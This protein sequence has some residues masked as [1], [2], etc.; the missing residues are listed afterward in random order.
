MKNWERKNLSMLIES[1]LCKCNLDAII[2]CEKNRQRKKKTKQRIRGLIQKYNLKYYCTITIDPKIKNAELTGKTKITQQLR[3]M[4]ER[5]GIRYCFIPEYFA[6]QV[7]IH[8]HGFISLPAKIELLPKVLSNGFPKID[9]YGNQIF[10]IPFLE[11]NF[12][13]SEIVD[14][15]K[16]KHRVNTFDPEMKALLNYITKYIT[17][18]ASFR[19][20]S[21]KVDISKLWSDSVIDSGRVNCS[22][23]HFL[24]GNEALD[25][26]LVK[27]YYDGSLKI[28]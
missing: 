20:L 7:K 17:K 3:K 13:F 22:K 21:S 11:K 24:G 9:K 12:G 28:E 16:G 2:E 23:I 15:S 6:D 5:Y 1:Q 18:E 26:L 4:F 14:L 10:T 19:L 25:D 27:M 8:Y